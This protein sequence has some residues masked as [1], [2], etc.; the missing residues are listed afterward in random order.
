MLFGLNDVTVSRGGRQILSHIDFYIQGTEKIALV[1]P[2]GA[3]KSSLLLVLAGELN[4]DRDD[5]RSMEAV[6]TSR[7]LTV[8]IVH[9]TVFENIHETVGEYF[10]RAYFE[11]ND[12]LSV[13]ERDGFDKNLRRMDGETDERERFL[14]ELE[15]DK[16]LCGFG[17]DKTDKNREVGS[18]SGG[19]QTKLELIGKLMCKPDVLLLDEPT[20]HLDMQS[21]EW[22]EEYLKAYKGAVVFVSHDRFFIDRVADV[23]CEVSGGQLSR[24]PGNY[25]SYRQAKDKNYQIAKKTYDRYMEEKLRLEEV[26]KRFKNKP[27][28]ASMARA[29]KKQLERMGVPKNPG[30]PPVHYHLGD[31]TPDIVGAKWV[32]EAEHLKVGYDKVLYEAGLR[33]RRGQKIAV[34]G[35]NGSGKTALLKTVAGRIPHKGGKSTLGNQIL[36]GYYDQKSGDE[37]QNSTVFEHFHALFPGMLTAEVY[38]HLAGWGFDGAQA[39]QNVSTL[40]GGEK[41]KLIMAELLKSKP[42]FLVLDEPTNHMDMET[43][44]LIEEAFNA[45]KGT[46]LFVSHDRYFISQVADALLIIADGQLYYYPFG[47]ENYLR[48]RLSHEEEIVPGELKAEDAARIAALRA[49]PKREFFPLR[50][51]STEKAYHDWRRRLMDEELERSIA[52]FEER[53]LE[54]TTIEGWEE[55]GEE[56]DSAYLMWYDEYLKLHEE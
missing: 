30:S 24:Y 29:K 36:L 42:N 35:V 25:T 47:Y 38:S 8:S 5:K 56:L 40:S 28:K 53:M 7:K 4:I 9:Q 16:M 34:L 44:E 20:N 41:S 11:K 55:A 51:E 17:F 52:R 33:I 37:V 39:N 46:M 1:G 14:F 43:K 15:C 27:T 18:F 31:I 12:T 19:Q 2:N 49:V 3:G 45:Y 10:E 22:L 48:K 23:I 26:I 6:T 21:V 50:E 32:Y 13:D 54:L